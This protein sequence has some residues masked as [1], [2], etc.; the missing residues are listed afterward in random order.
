MI[1]RFIHNIFLQRFLIDEDRNM[2]LVWV[3]R[4]IFPCVVCTR[5]TVCACTMRCHEKTRSLDE[6]VCNSAVGLYR[7]PVV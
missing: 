2:G 4:Q 6:G 1:K 3:T 7:A 5:L